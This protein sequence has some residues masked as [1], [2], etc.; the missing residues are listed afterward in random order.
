MRSV[1]IDIESCDRSP[2]CPARRVCP[3][4]AIVPVP[5]GRYPGENGYVVDE[6]R[7]T[8]C[9]ICVRSCPGRAVRVA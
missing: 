8:G 5:G 4:G 2:A 3:R 6:T 1:T 7:C 9:A